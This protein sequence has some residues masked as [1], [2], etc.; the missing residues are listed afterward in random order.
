MVPAAPQSLQE[1]VRTGGGRERDDDELQGM[2]DGSTGF[3]SV[4]DREKTKEGR[5]QVDAIFR[6]ASPELKEAL[7]ARRREKHEKARARRAMQSQGNEGS[8][9]FSVEMDRDRDK[10]ASFLEVDE[11]ENMLIGGEGRGRG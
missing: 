7:L 3:N 10:I 5:E 9:V 11:F 6:W 2:L 8:P 1:L 4:D